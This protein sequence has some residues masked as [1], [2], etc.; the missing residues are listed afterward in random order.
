MI[1]RRKKDDVS[2][3]R[4]VRVQ[5]CTDVSS[6]VCGM[7]RCELLYMYMYIPHVLRTGVSTY[8]RMYIQVQ[9]VQYVHIHVRVEHTCMS[10][11]RMAMWIVVIDVQHL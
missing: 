6:Y 9:H 5:Y 8:V 3:Y 11:E 2:T 7:Y 4:W 10:E 1:S